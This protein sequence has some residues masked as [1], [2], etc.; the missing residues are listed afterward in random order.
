MKKLLLILVVAFAGL[1]ANAS[2]HKIANSQSVTAKKSIEWQ[3]NMILTEAKTT[4]KKPAAMDCYYLGVYDVYVDG[5]YWGV[6][7][8]WICF[9]NVV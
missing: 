3:S 7:D 8:V 5:E 4:V 6:Y 9:F 2:N 1:L